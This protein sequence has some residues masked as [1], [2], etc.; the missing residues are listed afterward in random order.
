MKFENGLD[1]LKTISFIKQK[2]FFGFNIINNSGDVPFICN[3]CRER[4]ENGMVC[5]SLVD[6]YPIDKCY[7]FS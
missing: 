3:T 5:Q 7:A 2:N 1:S 6:M 4:E